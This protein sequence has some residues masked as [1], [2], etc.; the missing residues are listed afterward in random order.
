MLCAEQAGLLLAEP[1]DEPVE[2]RVKSVGGEEDEQQVEVEGGAEGLPLADVGFEHV[3]DLKTLPE[4]E[5]ADERDA[6]VFVETSIGG[7]GPGDA[8]EKEDGGEGELE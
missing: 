6:V 7:E 4:E 1:G 5:H 2:A 3:E 8:A